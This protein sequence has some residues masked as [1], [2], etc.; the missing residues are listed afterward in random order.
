MKGELANLIELGTKLGLD[1]LV[2]VHDEEDV[3]K[4]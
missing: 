2:E 4:R 3:Q 1:T